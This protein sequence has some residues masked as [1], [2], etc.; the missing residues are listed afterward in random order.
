MQDTTGIEK[1]DAKIDEEGKNDGID[2]D[3]SDYSDPVA[4]FLIALKA[5]ETE[6][7]S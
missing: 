5:P 1:F 6:T 3:N 7:I 2:K 4:N